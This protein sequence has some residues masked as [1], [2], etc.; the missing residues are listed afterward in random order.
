MARRSILDL[1]EPKRLLILETAAFEFAAH[2]FEGA[3]LN[4]IIERC[5]MS[6]SSFYYYFDDKAQLF[7]VLIDQATAR[8]A[9]D[10][11]FPSPESLSGADFWAQIEALFDRMLVV[12][13]QQP[14]FLALGRLFYRSPDAGSADIGGVHL[15]VR[16]WVERALLAGQ[17]CGAIRTD[18]PFSL[19]AESVFALLQALDRWSVEHYESL[20]PDEARATASTQTDFL[21][22]MLALPF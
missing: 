20:T 11:G 17:E 21:K 15:R 1:P 3:S 13:E 22:R 4:R 8:L 10:V 14:W 2:G 9:A 6:K 16:R 12:A 19:L 18:V 7:A 5:G